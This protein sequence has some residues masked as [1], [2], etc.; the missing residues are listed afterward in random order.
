MALE[1]DSVD[2]CRDS[3][4][5]RIGKLKPGE[6]ASEA[7]RFN[8]DKITAAE[9]TSTYEAFRNHASTAVARAKKTTRG[10][11]VIESG[12][13]RTKAN[14]FIATVAVTRES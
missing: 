7:K 6:T 2:P 1:T 9:V 14:A 13:F 11:Y 8:L 12:D 5:I 4:G 3:F 10:S